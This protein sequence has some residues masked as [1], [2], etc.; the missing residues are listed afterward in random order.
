MV[1]R[2]R[3][4]RQYS[5][6][7]TS[8]WQ[9]GR[10]DAVMNDPI[11]ETGHA[12]SE[13]LNPDHVRVSVW[14][15]CKGAGGMLF[16]H[17]YRILSYLSDLML[18]QEALLSRR[19]LR[20]FCEQGF[21]AVHGASYM[22]RDSLRD[23]V[24]TASRVVS[25]AEK[26]RII[27][28]YPEPILNTPKAALV[29][30]YPL[31]GRNDKLMVVNIHATLIRRVKRAAEELESLMQQLPAHSGP[32]IFAGDFNTF[33]ANYLDTISEVLSAYGL[34]RVAIDND[35][36]SPFGSLD[37]IFVRGLRIKQVVVDTTIASSDHF[38]IICHLAIA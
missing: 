10:I 11:W 36:R 14:N 23:G 2:R 3:P 4:Q 30:F 18:L 20:M 33:T 34:K 5:K 32:M 29:S 7:I 15:I 25:H 6:L 17:D 22:R 19:S 13:A 24:L 38:P 27:C 21:E 37:Q 31:L 12:E 35:P 1:N 26:A 28:K 9:V 8:L 16:E